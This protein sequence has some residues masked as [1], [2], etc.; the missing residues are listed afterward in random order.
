MRE[1]TF[2]RTLLGTLGLLISAISL[3]PL[4]G[5]GPQGSHAQPTA[6]L[7][8]K[9]AIDGKPV[10]GKVEG[11][12]DFFPN[13]EGQA[14]PATCQLKE[15]GTYEAKKVPKGSV[16]V[17]FNLGKYTGR[18]ITMDGSPQFEERVDLLKGRPHEVAIEV[19]EDGQQNFDL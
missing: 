3:G 16:I 17:K 9:V 6:T 1:A 14:P 2:K 15:D 4:T 11:F 12:I 5:C 13:G 19:T 10:T 7:T 18:M 8:G